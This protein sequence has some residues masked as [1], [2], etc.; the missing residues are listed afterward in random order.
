MVNKLPTER[1]K[2]GY[3]VSKERHMSTMITVKQTV[4]RMVHWF[5]RE[6]PWLEP[7]EPLD[8][9]K[10][11]KTMKGKQQRRTEDSHKKFA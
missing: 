5:L 10:R 4:A 7:P 1:Q 2:E 8:P 3:P 11:G 9:K 6:P